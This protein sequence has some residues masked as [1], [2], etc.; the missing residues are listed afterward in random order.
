MDAET[1]ARLD[2]IQEHAGEIARM[3]SAFSRLAIRYIPL[4]KNIR[5][6]G[7]PLDERI[8]LNLR[9]SDWPEAHK[10]CRDGFGNRVLGMDINWQGE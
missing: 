1:L 10:Y 9:V 7:G 5:Y 3:Q 4:L 8:V 2:R 6:C